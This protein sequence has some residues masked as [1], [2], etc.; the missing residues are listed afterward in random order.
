MPG[1]RRAPVVPGDHRR[2]LA[3]RVEQADHV[4]DQVQERVLLDLLRRVGL[5][6]AAHVG[7][8]GVEAGLGQGAELVA[9]GVPGFGKAV[10]ED[11]ERPAPCSAT[12]MRM[13]LVST[14]RCV[15]SVIG[16]LA[17]DRSRPLQVRGRP[18][19]ENTPRGD[20]GT[21]P[22][23]GVL[24]AT[25]PPL[26]RRPHEL[27]LVDD[28]PDTDNPRSVPMQTDPVAPIGINHLV[29]NVRNM[30]ESHRFWTEIVGLKQVGAVRPRG[31]RGSYAHD[32]V[33]Q[34][35]PQWPDDAS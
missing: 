11:D 16:P 28:T 18:G 3:E 12:C 17:A 4:A 13:P 34:R 20:Q 22:S 23:A 31:D 30:A 5:A 2:S 26:P 6:V 27:G 14:K 7:R 32:A 19:P 8:D 35:R 15:G 9:P 24:R 10:A 33:L 29:I 1:H 21:K 25:S